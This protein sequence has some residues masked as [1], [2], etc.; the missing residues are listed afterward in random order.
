MRVEKW[1]E[2]RD[3]LM[4]FISKTDLLG[5]DVL[6]LCVRY[7]DGL[8]KDEVQGCVGCAL[9]PT[10]EVVV[11]EELELIAAREAYTE[12]TGNKVPNNKKNKVEWLKEQVEQK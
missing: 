12:K 11:D 3:E 9:P 8:T 4:T 2:T 7:D 6:G 10:P 1:F 5:A